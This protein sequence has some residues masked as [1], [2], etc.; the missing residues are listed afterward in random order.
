M[1]RQAIER[2]CC[3][4]GVDEHLRP[5]GEGEIGRDQERCVF[6]ELADQVEQQLPAGLAE[7][8]VAELVDDDEIVAQ[9]LLGQ[10]AAAAGGLLLLEL[11]DQIDEV[12]EPA[13]GADADDRRG[14]GDAE[15]RFARAGRDSDMAPGFWRAKRRST[16]PFIRSQA[17]L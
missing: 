13:P 14:D 6:V 3:H 15:M 2:G 4:F 1:V 9:Q 5:I 12:E 17:G 8:Q 7:R 16:T 10:A 11:V